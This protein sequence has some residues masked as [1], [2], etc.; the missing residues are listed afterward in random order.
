[1]APGDRPNRCVG[2]TAWYPL[3]A[4]HLTAWPGA[5]THP[6]ILRDIQR[7]RLK[8]THLALGRGSCGL[9]WLRGPGGASPHPT[10]SL[11]PLATRQPCPFMAHPQTAHLHSLTPLQGGWWEGVHLPE[12]PRLSQVLGS[13]AC[14]GILTVPELSGL[15]LSEPLSLHLES[16][17]EARTCRLM[18]LGGAVCDGLSAV[19]GVSTHQDREASPPTCQLGSSLTLTAAAWWG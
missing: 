10:P 5:E 1:M 17:D 8:S 13:Q 14:E 12:A 15:H 11:W 3:P 7:D 4:L 2:I 9:L 16:G 18:G 19:A 6:E